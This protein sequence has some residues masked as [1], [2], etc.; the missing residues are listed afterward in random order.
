MRPSTVGALSVLLGIILLQA[1][2][3]AEKSGLCPYVGVPNTI[4]LFRCLSV[5][6]TVC[7]N[8]EDCEGQQKCCSESC[9]NRCRDPV[10][11]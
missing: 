7:K 4:M 6:D 10:F 8:D 3:S 9:V 11:V 5:N 1:V 2:S